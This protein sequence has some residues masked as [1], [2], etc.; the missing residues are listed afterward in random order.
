MSTHI[1]VSVRDL[2]A[3]LSHYLAQV[4]AGQAVEITSHRHVVARLCK[5][6]DPQAAGI[7]RLTEQGLAQWSG[8]KPSGADIEL[9]PAG[10]SVSE[11]V[12]D[13]RG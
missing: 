6:P 1:S 13:D 9:S 5:A 2:R 4:R 8:G 12:L 11:M 10:R 3:R 7:A